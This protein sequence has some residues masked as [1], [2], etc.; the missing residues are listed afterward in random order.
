MLHFARGAWC[1]HLE[2]C[3]VQL[4]CTSA[5]P[6]DRGNMEHSADAIGIVA[7]T[8]LEMDFVAESDQHAHEFR[9]Q[10]AHRRSPH[11]AARNEHEH[12]RDHGCAGRGRSICRSLNTR[13]CREI[14]ML[15]R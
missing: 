13:F 12:S 9:R 7:T 10:D 14:G 8:L 2:S 11:C 3:S 6:M 1:K 4:V 15:D 5:A